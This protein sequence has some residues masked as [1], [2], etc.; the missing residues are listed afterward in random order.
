MAHDNMIMLTTTLK[1]TANMV[2]WYAVL[3]T[4][5]FVGHNSFSIQFPIDILTYFMLWWLVWNGTRY[6]ILFSRSKITLII[7]CAFVDIGYS[8]LQIY[9]LRK[10]FEDDSE[11]NLRARPKVFL[12]VFNIMCNGYVYMT[13]IYFGKC[14]KSFD[15]EINDKVQQVTEVDGNLKQIMDKAKNKGLARQTF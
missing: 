7:V 8:L 13:F 6:D 9:E 5:A 2:V 15:I 10:D 11:Q 4:Y 1:M 14:K 3:K 12:H